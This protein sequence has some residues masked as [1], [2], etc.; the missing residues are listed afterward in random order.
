M[1]ITTDPLRPHLLDI[2]AAP[3][4]S[5]LILAGGFGLLLKQEHLYQTEARTLI[6]PLPPARA[7]QDLDF[8][9]G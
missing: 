2:L 5:D 6:T 1:S 7:T 3:V 4:S 9:L 8:F